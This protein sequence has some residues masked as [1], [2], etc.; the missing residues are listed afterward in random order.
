MAQL[1]KIRFL[2]LE[3]NIVI[4]KA[5]MGS[6]MLIIIFSSPERPYIRSPYIQGPSRKSSLHT[7]QRLFQDL[8]PPYFLLFYQHTE[9]N[10]GPIVGCISI[11]LGDIDND[12][13]SIYSAHSVDLTRSG[14]L[15][16]NNCICRYV[17][18]LRQIINPLW[19]TERRTRM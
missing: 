11:F 16:M 10:T 15:H 1:I 4:S 2:V 19:P 12:R 17:H 6:S 18:L 3:I 5:S 14:A 13:K 9:I 7:V 8:L